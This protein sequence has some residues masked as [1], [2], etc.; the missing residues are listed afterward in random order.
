MTL[1][2]DGSTLIKPVGTHAPFSIHQY[3]ELS[4]AS[5]RADLQHPA[6]N[7][8]S[9]DEAVAEHH[10]LLAYGGLAGKATRPFSSPIVHLDQAQ[11]EALRFETDRRSLLGEDGRSKPMGVFSSKRQA[12]VCP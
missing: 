10:A 8:C 11:D 4:L 3:L 6:F 7:S 5:H 9:S 1:R 12:R 2:F